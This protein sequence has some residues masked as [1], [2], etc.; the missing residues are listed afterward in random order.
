MQIKR[1]S[2]PTIAGVARQMKAF[3]FRYSISTNDFLQQ[4][5]NGNLVSEDDA[6]EWRYLREQFSAL[7]EAAIERLYSALPTGS[8]ARL[9]NCENSSELLAA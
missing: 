7:Q 3:E 8:E 2:A 5:F 6:M 9:K 1:R 4:D